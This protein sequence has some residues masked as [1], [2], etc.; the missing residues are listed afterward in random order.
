MSHG[1]QNSRNRDIGHVHSFRVDVDP[2][3]KYD[4]STLTELA[5]QADTVTAVSEHTTET[6]RE[7]IGIDPEVVYNGVDT[8]WFT[9][10]MIVQPCPPTTISTIQYSFMLDQ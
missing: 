4:T 5:R 3:G 6:V 10:T 1:S 7:Y 9:Q 2:D 8:E